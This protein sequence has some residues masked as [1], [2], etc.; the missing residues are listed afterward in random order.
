MWIEKFHSLLL[1]DDK[2]ISITKENENF[3]IKILIK[4]LKMRKTIND[5]IFV[6][7]KKKVIKYYFKNYFNYSN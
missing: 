3:S 4:R 2:I 5:N 1:F 6:E 7:R